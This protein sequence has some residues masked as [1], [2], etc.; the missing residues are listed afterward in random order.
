MARLYADENFP[1]SAC[2]RLR[3]LGHDV[4]TAYE[5]GQAN[6]GI[7]DERV[8]DFAHREGRALLTQN[9]RHFA[10]LHISG[11]PHS[12]IIV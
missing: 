8:P 12:G 7:H 3:Q 2:H 9:R 1:R 4:L 5:A 6:Q 11:F 10:R